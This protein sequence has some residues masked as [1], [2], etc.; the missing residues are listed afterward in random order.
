MNILIAN[1]VQGE[2]VQILG[3]GPTVTNVG[4]QIWF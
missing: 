2:K 3:P 4:A 1:Q